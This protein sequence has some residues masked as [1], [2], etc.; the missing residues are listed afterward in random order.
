[1][2]WQSRAHA[3]NDS[4]QQV[5]CTTGSSSKPTTASESALHESSQPGVSPE[6]QQRAAV[7]GRPQIPR[8]VI[9]LLERHLHREGSDVKELK[10]SCELAKLVQGAEPMV[11]MS[12]TIVCP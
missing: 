9:R 2:K 8:D 1:M 10:P 12:C 7:D 5:A 11:H 6:G 4:M 3:C